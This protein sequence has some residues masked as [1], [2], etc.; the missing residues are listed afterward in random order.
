MN[1]KLMKFALNLSGFA[2]FYLVNPHTEGKLKREEE[3]IERP[4]VRLMNS[5]IRHP[6]EE[7]QS[8]FD[9]SRSQSLERSS[10]RS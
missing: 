3:C 4:V 7:P 1:A 6:A 8:W 9:R 10:H 2:P 5:D